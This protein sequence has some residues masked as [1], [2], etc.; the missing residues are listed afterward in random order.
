MST[1]KNVDAQLKAIAQFYMQKAMIYVA[2]IYTQI[3]EIDHINKDAIIQSLKT[4][5][6]PEIKKHVQK[7]IEKTDR[8]RDFVYAAVKCYPHKE[9]P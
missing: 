1:E 2:D 9:V 5:I 6:I 4:H 7:E 8:N 3:L